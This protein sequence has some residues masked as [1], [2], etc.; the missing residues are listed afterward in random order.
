MLHRNII[1]RFIFY[2]HVCK[3]ILKIRLGYEDIWTDRYF[4]THNL[5][6]I[7]FINTT[8]T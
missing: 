8:I 5:K 6:L 7:A 4:D 2:V 1:K 3:E